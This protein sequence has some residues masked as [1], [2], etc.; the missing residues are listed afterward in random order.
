VKTV[1]TRWLRIGGIVAAYAI[2]I[3]L[4]Q[5]AGDW[6]LDYLEMDLRPSKQATI[7]KIVV[8]TLALYILLLALPFM[9]GIEI[10]LG[11]IAMLGRD[12]CFL[13]YLSTVSALVL[14][15][16]IGRLVPTQAVIAIFSWLGLTR[17]R[18]L[19]A[20]IAPMHTDERLAFLLSRVPA[21]FLSVLLRHRYLGLAVILNV[22]GNALIGGGGGIALAAGMSRIFNF[23]TYLITVALAVSPFPLIYYFVVGAQ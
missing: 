11:L 18:D 17:A 20:Y 3:Y 15:Y 14:A 10:G 9:P 12:I 7:H 22:P 23:P 5:I 6:A 21:R 2:L 13:V 4:G 16:A 19:V 1:G 8:G